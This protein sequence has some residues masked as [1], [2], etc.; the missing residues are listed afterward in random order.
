MTV[1]G[2]KERWTSGDLYERYVGRWSRPVAQNFLAWLDAPAGARLA[3]RRLRYRLPDRDDRQE[4]RTKTMGWDRHVDRVPRPR[5]AVARPRWCRFLQADAEALPLADGAFDRAVSGLV[6]NFVRDPRR[7]AAEMVRV[8]RPGGEIAL[9]VWDYAGKMELMRHFWDAAAAVDPRGAEM[10]EGTRF[11]ICRPEALQQLFEA[12]GLLCKIETQANDVPTIFRD[13]GRLLV[14]VPR[15][16]GTCTGLLRVFA[17]TS[18]CESVR[19]GAGALADAAGRQHPS[20]RAS[21][22]RAWLQSLAGVFFRCLLVES[23][24]CN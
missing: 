12:T 24:S 21:L 13:F 15:R 20:G 14:P 11:P 9:Y 10:D 16:P 23:M 2:A 5:P 8:A 3:R 18:A 4:L 22:G 7:A 17:R 6:L 19:A 1:T